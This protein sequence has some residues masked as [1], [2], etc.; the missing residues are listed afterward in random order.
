MVQ[1]NRQRRI[2]I[3]SLLLISIVALCVAFSPVFAKTENAA[4]SDVLGWLI[5]QFF[6]LLMRMILGFVDSFRNVFTS[7]FIPDMDLGKKSAFIDTF[8]SMTAIKNAFAA[9]GY[10]AAV[11]LFV[12]AIIKGM[13]GDTY[14]GENPW[15]LTIRFVIC[16]FLIFNLQ[17]F[18]TAVFTF[19]RGMVQTIQNVETPTQKEI[20]KKESNKNMFSE[21]GTSNTQSF[22]ERFSKNIDETSADGTHWAIS[23]GS[24]LL[25][26]LVIV[27][28]GIS[29]I[30][31]MLEIV[32][33]YVLCG[34]L[35]LFMPIGIAGITTEETTQNFRNYMM[36]L[37]TTMLLMGMNIFFYK[38]ADVAMTTLVV[39]SA[40]MGQSDY[41]TRYFI[42]CAMIL[43]MLR[44]AKRFD[45]YLNSMGF[46]TLRTGAGMLGEMIASTAIAVEF[47]K[48]TQRGIKRLGKGAVAAT[49]GYDRFV[50]KPLSE[51]AKSEKVREH[52]QDR[53]ERKKMTGSGDIA[54]GKLKA[55]QDAKN[56]NARYKASN[57]KLQTAKT[58]QKN[59][60][61][62]KAQYNHLS[63][64]AK[65]EFE[66]HYAKAAASFDA[67]T[68]AVSDWHDSDEHKEFQEFL[69][70]KGK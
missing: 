45:N 68:N 39:S 3:V 8:G 44:I 58:K 26:V 19:G 11:L 51:K 65:Q 70:K 14:R 12:L 69:D 48:K 4:I 35:W 20:I 59:A 7:I 66:N 18:T 42:T 9:I 28:I 24:G 50:S 57:K 47:M 43:A 60:A 36:T 6:N 46:S 17:G 2:L 54:Q 63:P 56:F 16:I 15:N 22:S 32:E 41:I 52:Y 13:F 34:I 67:S 53:L 21:V 31:L 37:F 55:K 49:N 23:F 29:F 38:V 25:T 5:A 27:A 40:Q 1:T 64:A 62:L 61:R 33:R 10:S 30:G